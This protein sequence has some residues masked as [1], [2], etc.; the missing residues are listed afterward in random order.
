[1]DRYFHLVCQ[2]CTRPQIFSYSNRVGSFSPQGRG[3]C[4]T[5]YRHFSPSL[6]EG[7][8]CW[9]LEGR[10]RRCK[11][12]V[13]HKEFS[14]N[15]D[16]APGEDAVYPKKRVLLFLKWSD[17]FELKSCI[18]WFKLFLLLFLVATRKHQVCHFLVLG[19]TC[20]PV[21]FITCEPSRVAGKH[22]SEDGNAWSFLA[23]IP[24][25]PGVH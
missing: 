9:Y 5:V 24:P 10:S 2:K 23:N 21:T 1:M 12:L 7:E 22:P 15:I 14:R 18:S 6:A 17:V 25:P 4:G 11:T 8:G 3:M 13:A 16:S 19:V 20:L